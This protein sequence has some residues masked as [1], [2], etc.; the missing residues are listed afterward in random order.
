MAN[1]PPGARSTTKSTSPRPGRTYEL[2]SLSGAESAG[3]LRFLMNLDDPSPEVTEAVAAGVAWFESAKLSG[4]RQTRVDGDKVI[5]EDVDAQPLWAR[6]YEIETNRPIFCGRDGVKKYSLA[7]IEAERRNGYA[8]YGDWGRPLASEYTKW[9]KNRPAPAD[10]NDGAVADLK[11]VRLTCEYAEN[12]LGVDVSNP[13]LS[14]KLESDARGRRQ[15]AYRILASSSAERLAAGEGDL[16]D[17]GRVTL[18]E[19]THVA[20]RGRKLASSQQ[21]FWKVRVWDEQDNA[22]TWSEPASWTMGLLDESDW[23][24][25]WIGSTTDSQSLLLRRGIAVRHALR[26]A[27]AHVCGLGHYEMSINGA[28]VGEDLLAPGWSKYD[29]TCLYD[30]YDVT[31][32]LQEGDNGIGLM[33]GNG[34]YNV[35]GGR[36]IKF[37]GSFGPLKAI[38]HL[39]LEYADGAVETIGTD[40][41]WRTH[42][43]PIT[44]SCVFG[45]EDY[46][47]RLEPRGWDRPGFDDLGWPVAQEVDGPGGA[48]KGLS[49]AAAPIR[50]FDVLEPVSV[51]QLR[52]G[53][54]VYDLGQNASIMPRLKTTGPA[55]SAVRITPAELLK[56]DGSVDRGS[57]GGGQA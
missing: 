50:A 28:R 34:M 19:T 29:K 43:G 8:W 49:C 23:R 22:S 38:C 6:F 21:V 53:V 18:G 55:G 35:R 33:L 46:D 11:I 31:P 40:G 13:R 42:P 45:G 10:T 16:W 57:C 51:R 44:F 17:S 41:R 52:P 39:R 1:G 37:K 20:Y 5:V 9:Q 36:Y 7:E 4:I 48:L 32:L 54:A 14:W 24:A 12:P 47:A 30:T 3:I 26:R 25:H 2:V 27:V 15:S 56:D